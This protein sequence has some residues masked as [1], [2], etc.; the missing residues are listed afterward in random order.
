MI[1]LCEQRK[2]IQGSFVKKSVNSVSFLYGPHGQCP[3][4]TV[5]YLHFEMQLAYEEFTAI[6]ASVA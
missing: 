6:K 1:V 4:S 2:D 3:L 5:F